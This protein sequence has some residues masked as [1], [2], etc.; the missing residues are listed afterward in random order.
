MFEDG[1]KQIT[2]ADLYALDMHKMDEWRTLISDESAAMV[3]NLWFDNKPTV[4]R[5][6]WKSYEKKLLPVL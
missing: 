5:L 6:R 2:L 4:I 1:D 3:I